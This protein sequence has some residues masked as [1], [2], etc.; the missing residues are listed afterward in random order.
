MLPY[1][2]APSPPMTPR[3]RRACSQA[4]HIIKTDGHVLRGAR[5]VLFF[6]EAG[7]GGSLA[8][9]ISRSPLLWLIEAGYRV[10]ANN[11]PFFAKFL[12][13]R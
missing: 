13:R 1:Q 7:G 5:A 4:V 9:L 2:S 3:L 8:R 11:R 10:V 6:W 12:F